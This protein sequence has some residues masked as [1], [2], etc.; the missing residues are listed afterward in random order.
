MANTNE[1]RQGTNKFDVVGVVKEHNLE[2]GKNNDGE[3]IVKGNLKVA[4]GENSDIKIEVYGKRYT[5]NDNES[6]QFTNLN[7]LIKG[8]YKT[9]A[10]AKPDEY[11]GE[12]N[13]VKEG[14]TI[15]KVRI[16][17][18]G[19]FTPNFSEDIYKDAKG[20]VKSNIKNKLGFGSFKI[21]DTLT[22]EDYKAEFE[23][24][25]YVV[26]VQAEVDSQTSEETGRAI[27][28]ILVP[29][30]G[31]SVMPM[32]LH[33]GIILD[34]DGETEID[35]GGAIL[36]E[37]EVGSTATFT[38]S[39]VNQAI[40]TEKRKTGIGRAKIEKETSYV[41]EFQIFG[42]YPEEE[43]ESKMF[44]A[45]LIREAQKQRELK[46]EEVKNKEDKPADSKPKRG[47]IGAKAGG[48]KPAGAG[49][50]RPAGRPLF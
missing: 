18:R 42:A 40:V 21:D 15:A 38:G 37:L 34:E 33:A 39:I 26:D 2:L 32:T 12:G 7:S 47:G 6:A 3:E 4:Y 44:D 23:V 28:K 17:G 20:V 24:E 10:T 29:V 31:G 9:M 43:D 22:P 19:D 35:F 25:G 5:K 13:L 46:K 30:Y 36:S 50:K 14:D 27:I 48:T 16:F 1:L 45:E 49:S 11:D 41:N 8:E